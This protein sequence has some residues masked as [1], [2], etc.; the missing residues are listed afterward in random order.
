MNLIL[1]ASEAI[2]A[3]T[4]AVTIVTRRR[5]VGPDERDVLQ[6][7]GEPLPPGLYVE[8]TVGDDGEGMDEPT[9]S[10]IFE[11]F[12]ST[13]R[14][15]RGLGLAATQGI[16]RGIG[17]P[18]GGEPARRR[19]HVHGAVPGDPR[20]AGRAAPAPSGTAT[21]LVLVVD[22]EEPCGR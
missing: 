21:G 14:T 20:A 8:L 13:K 1:N 6:P 18:E 5:E 9:R 19:H 16:V 10:R 3:R 15:G 7:T 2:G 22:D 11:P 17:R 4:G 12:F